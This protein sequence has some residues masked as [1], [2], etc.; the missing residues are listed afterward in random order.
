[1]LHAAIDIVHS[2]PPQI[3]KASAAPVAKLLLDPRFHKLG[4]RDAA[5]LDE[6]GEGVA[7]DGEDDPSEEGAEEEEREEVVAAVGKDSV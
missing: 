3:P 4:I 2:I 6:V 7:P 1:M 5:A